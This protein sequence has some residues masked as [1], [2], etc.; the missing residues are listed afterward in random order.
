M[1]MIHWAE[2]WATTEKRENRIEVNLVN[3]LQWMRGVTRKD[4]IRNDHVYEG[5][6]EWRRISKDHGVTIELMRAYDEER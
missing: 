1:S 4:N 2:T 3:M 5:Q 6:R